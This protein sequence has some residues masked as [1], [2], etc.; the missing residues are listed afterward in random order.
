M[1]LEWLAKSRDLNII[2]NYWGNLTK[3]VQHGRQ[4]VNIN[5]LKKN[6]NCRVEII[7]PKKS[8]KNY[9]D[10]CFKERLLL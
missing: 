7:K 8:L 10:L 1:A 3:V 2:E 4:F 6:K 5:E 9:I